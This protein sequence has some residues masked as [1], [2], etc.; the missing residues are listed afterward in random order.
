MFSEVNGVGSIK[1][2]RDV[3]RNLTDM[4]GNFHKIFTKVKDYFIFQLFVQ[5]FF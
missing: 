5:I 2:L 3:P 1:K 4:D